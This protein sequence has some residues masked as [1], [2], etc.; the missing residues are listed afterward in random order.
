MLRFVCREWAQESL[1]APEPQAR[2]AAVVLQPRERAN[3]VKLVIN[4]QFIEKF[5]SIKR[6]MFFRKSFSSKFFRTRTVSFNRPRAGG[7]KGTKVTPS[8]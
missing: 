4:L 7:E 5:G 6:G 8:S 2:A 1:P 3:S